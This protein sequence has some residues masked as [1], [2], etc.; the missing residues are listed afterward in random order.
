MFADSLLESNW[1]NR[2]HRGWTTI[3]SFAMQTLAVGIL[4][5][6]PLIYSEGLPKLRLTTIGAP[7]GPPP[8]KPPE[9]ARHAS[10]QMRPSTNPFQIVAPPQ[11]PP[12]I[13]RG[14]DEIPIPSVE[15]CAD[16]VSGDTGQPGIQNSVIDSIGSSANVAPP[17]PPKPTA[18]PPRVS[19]MMEGNL[20][21]KP[22]PVYPPMAR[23]ARIQ[24]AVVLRAIISKNG[25]IENL[26]A[27]SGHPMLIPAAIVA[28]KQWRYRPYVLNGEPV[29][30]ETRVTVNF[31]LSGG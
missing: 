15:A 16:C 19:R 21:Y 29:E 23:A 3:A 31:M 17:P 26:E 25:T 13:E 6:L 20:I 10:G 1:D 5:M 11:I 8:G 2:S 14:G 30:V 9:G 24:G 4:L 12:T 22:Q 7:L 18:P 27:L 28:V